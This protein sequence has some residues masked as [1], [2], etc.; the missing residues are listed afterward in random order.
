MCEV[1]N[2]ALWAGFFATLI[3]T[4]ITLSK[5]FQRRKHMSPATTND[6]KEH[7]KV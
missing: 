6:K 5:L 2:L 4:S 3:V 7:D 1:Y